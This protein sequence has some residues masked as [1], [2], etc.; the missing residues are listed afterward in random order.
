MAWSGCSV[1]AL[2]TTMIASPANRSMS[3]PSS[4][5]AGTAAAQYRFS[6]STTSLA[7]RSSEKPVYPA[8]SAKSTLA[9]RSSPPSRA[10]SGWRSRL[11]ANCGAT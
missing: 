5:T 7:G 2:K 8:R 10:R 4:R 1:T 6:I 11:V 9:S 3:P